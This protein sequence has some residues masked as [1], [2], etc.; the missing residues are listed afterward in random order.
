MTNKSFGVI[1][2]SFNPN[3]KVTKCTWTFKQG[4][5]KRLNNIANGDHIQSDYFE[6]KEDHMNA[7][8]YLTCYPK[9][10]NEKF[11]GCCQMFL[12]LSSIPNT[13]KSIKIYYYMKYMKHN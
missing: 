2:T 13:Y 6:T 12:Y 5:L 3:T 1:R 11:I 4:D 9:G 10:Y 8:W 7:K